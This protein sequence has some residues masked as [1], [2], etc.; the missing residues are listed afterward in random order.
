MAEDRLLLTLTISKQVGVSVNVF[1]SDENDEKYILLMQKLNERNK[2]EKGV[3]NHF[4]SI[5]GYTKGAGVEGSKVDIL[6]HTEEERRD[7]AEDN[8]AFNQTIKDLSAIKIDAVKSSKYLTKQDLDNIGKVI[9]K[10]YKDS[11]K[12]DPYMKDLDPTQ[13]FKANK[14]AWNRDYNALATAIREFREET[15]YLGEIK[16]IRRIYS[17]DNYGID[18]ITKLHTVVA[19]FVI[20]LGQLSKTPI[21][22]SNNYN[23]ERELGSFI[24]NG[25]E[26]GALQFV[27]L[28]DIS[29]DASYEGKPL[30]KA[31][32]VNN[33]VRDLR[34]RDLELAS[35]GMITSYNHLNTVSKQVIGATLPMLKGELGAESWQNQVRAKCIAREIGKSKMITSLVL[36]NAT[37]QCN[38][39]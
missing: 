30:V 35:Q 14:T 23:G 19:H 27:K 15:G 12:E 16:S 24:A 5:G 28:Q 37:Q 11:L 7:E 17:S 6:S 26:I 31:E 3:K 21:I 39:K 10:F 22:Y 9:D 13:Y 8:F 38:S 1:Y 25:T 34:D 33:V 32:V 18:N 29:Q 2:P 4:D 20:D 36:N